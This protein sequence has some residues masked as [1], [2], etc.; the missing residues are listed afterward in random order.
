MW[1]IVSIIFTAISAIVLG[2]WALYLFL[3]NKKLKVF[4]IDKNIKIKEIEIR[5][6]K[7]EYSN[8]LNSPA[9]SHNFNW[10]D[11]ERESINKMEKL[12]AELEHLKKLKEY[13]WLFKKT[14]EK[15]N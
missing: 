10:T 4:E 12:E 11:Y 6:Q 5:E 7:E 1:N 13:K 8:K 15:T 3:E 9:W 2:L 14:N